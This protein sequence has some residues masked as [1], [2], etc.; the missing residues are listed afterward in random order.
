MRLWLKLLA[1]L[2]NLRARV[3]DKWIKCGL[4]SLITVRSHKVR[5]GDKVFTKG[6]K[7]PIKAENVSCFQE[8]KKTAC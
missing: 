2:R 7:Q 6:G 5:L 8:G 3:V 1:I 4:P